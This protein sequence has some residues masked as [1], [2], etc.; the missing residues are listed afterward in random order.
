MHP[1]P[2]HAHTCPSPQVEVLPPLL[3]S[4]VMAA[5]SVIGNVFWLLWQT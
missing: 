2:L 4:F 3:Y 5:F 1:N